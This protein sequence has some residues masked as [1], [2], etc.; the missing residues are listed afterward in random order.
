MM[1]YLQATLRK[2]WSAT[3]RGMAFNLMSAHVEWQRDILFHAP[4]DRL[5]A[6]LTSEI[7]RHLAIRM[8]YGLYEYTVF[9]YR[10]PNR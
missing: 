10:Q 5:A 8:D 7:S 2:L 4:F 6:F 9:V 1:A 3:R